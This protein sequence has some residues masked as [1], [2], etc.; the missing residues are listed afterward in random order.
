VGGDLDDVLTLA[1]GDLMKA[2]VKL[3]VDECEIE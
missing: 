3:G 1:N 2:L